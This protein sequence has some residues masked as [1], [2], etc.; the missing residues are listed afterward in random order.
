M[1]WQYPEG[2]LGYSYGKIKEINGYE[3]SHLASTELGSSGSLIFMKSK[4]QVIGIHQGGQK[5]GSKNYGYFIGPIF[6]FF[7]NFSENNLI[8]DK[9]NN[10]E[11]EES[12]SIQMKNII[13]NRKESNLENNADFNN[14]KEVNKNN[15]D[16]LFQNL[17]RATKASCIINSKND[18]KSIELLVS[19]PINMGNR[20]SYFVYGLLTKYSILSEKK[21]NQEKICNYI[22]VSQ[23]NILNILFTMIHLYLVV[24]F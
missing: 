6:N 3:F 4:I 13:N 19:I 16:R 15:N 11:D 20:Y 12:N 2:R 8:L 7:K 22:L 9:D 21:L 14:Q 5:Y 23:I 24:L 18:A 17:L 10:L 1:Q